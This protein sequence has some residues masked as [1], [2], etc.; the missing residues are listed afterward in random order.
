MIEVVPSIIP[1]SLEELESELSLI[2]N[3]VSY[4][5]I[6]ISNGTFAPSKTWPFQNG[7]DFRQ[8]LST[9]EGLPFWKD[10]QFEIDMLVN[11][12]E[13]FIDDWIKVGASR[14]IIHL[15]TTEKIEEISEKIKKADMELGLS[16]NPNTPN[17]ILYKNLKLADF[18][19][20]MGN[21]KIG[22]HGVEF[23]E[24]VFKKISDL[25][26]R[27]PELIISIDIGVNKET[28]PK[29]VEMGVNKLVS[30]TTIFEAEDV[31]EQIK[32]FQNLK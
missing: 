21:D 22:F 7:S 4:V 12:P 32:E 29:L 25:R 26:Q 20:F 16:I 13:N 10:F 5:Q 19:Q 18:V 24:K 14:L 11:S 28:A 3:K 31:S 8:L 9:E 23:D 27:N 1:E 30:G 17:E 2:K 6:D 15:E